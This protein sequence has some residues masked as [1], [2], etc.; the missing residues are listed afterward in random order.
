MNRNS[1]WIMQT[2]ET[3][4][5]NNNNS[6]TLRCSYRRMRK[7]TYSK[8]NF[9]LG[10]LN[11]LAIIPLLPHQWECSAAKGTYPASLA[12]WAPSLE[13]MW[14]GRGRMSIT[15]LFSGLHM[16]TV[17]CTNPI[18]N[19]STMILILRNCPCFNSAHWL[20][21]RSLQCFKAQGIGYVLLSGEAMPIT[22][23]CNNCLVT[24]R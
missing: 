10:K 8:E 4:K 5:R 12:T 2:W 20:L 15:G 22:L 16:N 11:C 23:S 21:M 6:T 9:I 24:L 18:T 3:E 17:A 1:G 13:P 19:I 14:R 7:W